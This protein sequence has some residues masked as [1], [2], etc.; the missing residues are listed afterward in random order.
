MLSRTPE[1]LQAYQAAQLFGVSLGTLN[2]WTRR[3]IGPPC[4]VKDSHSWY[5]RETLRQWLSAGGA[6][7]LARGVRRTR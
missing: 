2:Y 4:V 1:L 6:S 3:G 7:Q 5:A